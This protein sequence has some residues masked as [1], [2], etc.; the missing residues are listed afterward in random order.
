MGLSE[1]GRGSP[2]M[3]RNQ[4]LPRLQELSS[5]GSHPGQGS[6]EG[7]RSQAPLNAMPLGETPPGQLPDEAHTPAR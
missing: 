2:Y 5:S 3:S 7:H 6:V 4:P 1:K